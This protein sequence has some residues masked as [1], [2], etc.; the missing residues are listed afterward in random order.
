MNLCSLYVWI[1]VLDTG[2][3]VFA[4]AGVAASTVNVVHRLG[5]DGANC[6]LRC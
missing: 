4:T 6:Y 2:V 1:K 5:Y 3:Y